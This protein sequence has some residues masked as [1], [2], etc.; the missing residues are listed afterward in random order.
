VSPAQEEAMS[1]MIRTSLLAAVLG[2]FAGASQGVAPA[3]RD[4]LAAA[5][6]VDRLIDQRLAEARVLASAQAG[7][8]AFLRRVS[9]DICGR[10]P[11]AARV[12]A[13]LS[14]TRPDRRRRLVDELLADEA[15]GRHFG[16]I[17]YH[18][19]VAP[20]DDN[21]RAIDP[22][23]KDW[24]AKQFNRNRP[25]DQV[26]T[27]ILTARGNRDAN[28]ATVFW[29]A[30]IEGAKAAHLKPA[31]ALG[32]A[33]QRFLGTRYQCAECHNH[34][35][36]GF[37]QTDFWSLAAFFGKT[38]VL[39]AGRK[40]VR[41]GGTPAVRDLPPG[42]GTIAIPDSKGKKVTPRFPDGTPLPAAGTPLRVAFARWATSAKNPAFAR[43]AV[44]RLWGH[45]LGRGIVDP[46]DDFREDTPPSHPEILD[47]LAAEFGAGGHDLKHLVR[48]ICNSRAY[49][50]SSDAL[51]GN[52]A[53][54]RLYSHA[55][56]KLMS[57]DVLVECL[58]Q[59]LGQPDDG[60]RR[61]K[62]A[63]GKAAPLLKLFDTGD[64]RDFSTDYSHGIPQVLHLMNGLPI[65]KAPF[66]RRLQKASSQARVIEGLYLA[67]V[68]RPPTAAERKR[69]SAHVAR[70]PTP[71]KGYADLLWALVNSS[72]FIFNH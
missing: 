58:N 11:T 21:R 23:F 4:P 63:V 3:P 8:A 70:C 59:A 47:L 33:S 54:D 64:E 67:T 2:L 49:Q 20:N 62:Q 18:L 19:L 13:F 7:D 35:F 45:F 27:D 24:L 5:A 50:R 14:D 72:E 10:I 69:A 41:R 57:P 53:D 34:P 40:A 36:T 71:S 42:M 1:I 6:A 32:T 66:L 17:W 26:V 48:C 30:H 61:K 44:N 60:R 37:K 65:E 28:P 22:S 43:A 39:R 15:F 38:E 9:L 16:T 29:L 46:V 51:P 25:W 12:S 56:V 55:A 52:A 68:S 31:D